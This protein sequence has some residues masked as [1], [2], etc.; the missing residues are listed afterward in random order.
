M[1]SIT[2]SGVFVQTCTWSAVGDVTLVGSEHHAYIPISVGYIAGALG[3]GTDICINGQVVHLE[4]LE[5]ARILERN[6]F[7]TETRPYKRTPCEQVVP[8]GDPGLEIITAQAHHKHR[9]RT[10]GER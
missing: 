10:Q 9:K 2:F 1:K 3:T 6:D 8:N 4:P 5:G 7:L